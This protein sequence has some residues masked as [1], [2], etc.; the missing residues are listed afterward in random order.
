MKT[1]VTASGYTS[2][3]N[4]N[5]SSRVTSFPTFSFQGLT[6][7]SFFSACDQ[8]SAFVK[9]AFSTL[10]NEAIEYKSVDNKARPAHINRRSY[11]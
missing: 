8:A 10:I 3:I 7:E 5:D 6:I 2:R 11:K 1:V 9:K 4:N